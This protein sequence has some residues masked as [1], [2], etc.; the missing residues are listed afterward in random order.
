MTLQGLAWNCRGLRKKGV[1]TFL[2]NLIQ[3]YQFH[4]VGLQETMIK[5]CE[6]TLLR[7]FDPNQ[8][9]IWMWNP[10]RGKS[11][12]TLVGVRIELYD[13]GSFR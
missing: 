5:D 8:E 4:F 13:V 1:A 10:S 12:G 3:E 9:F 2:K 7:K 6:D 11:G